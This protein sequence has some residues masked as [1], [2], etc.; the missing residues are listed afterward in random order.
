M[1]RNYFKT[2]VRNLWK[3]KTFSF[4]NVI[5][6]T[7]GLTSFILIALFIFDELTFDRLHKHVDNIYRVVERKTDAAGNTTN[8]AGAGLQVSARAK[9]DIPGIKD[10]ARIST[11][12]RANVKPS[13]NRTNIFYEDLIAGNAGILSV[14]SFPLLYGD[15]STALT[16]PH[17]VIITEESAKKFF[18]TSNAV[19]KLL[20]MWDSVPFRV[21]GVLKNFPA[22]SSISFNLMISEATF[23]KDAGAEGF[24]SN[25]WSSG[26]FATY[27][28]VSNNTD[29]P[30]LNNK[31]DHLIAA[32]HKADAG[33][34][35]HMQL[36][37]LKDVHFY[38]N[39]IEG[40][41]GKKGNISYIY[42]FLIVACFII[43]IACIN[44]M[45]L[46]TARFTNRGKEIAVRKV[47][48]ASRAMLIKQF[49][50]EA[51]L[52][53]VLSALLS[54]MLVN[55]LLPAFNSFTEKHLTINLHTDYRIWTGVL[56]IVMIVTLLAG[57]YPALFQS[58][59]N[60]LSLLKSKVKLGRGNI[61]LRRS[62][63]VFQFMI[64]IVLIAATI[65]IYE[66]MQYVNNKDMG[67][68]KEKS[69]VVAINS[70]DIRHAAATIK[71]EFT[72]LALVKS[73]A[74]T[75]RV[76]GDWKTITSVKVNTN[77]SNPADGKDMFF[78]G[79]D[80]QFLST[81]NI[82]LLKGRNFYSS[83]NGDSAAVLINETA[84]KQLGITNALDQTITIPSARSGSDYRS[85]LEKPFTATVVG[86]VK[87]F[88]FQ[89]LH[90]SIAPMVLGAP[91]NPVH[92]FDYFT[93]K[94][95]GGD[96]SATLTKMSAIL[97]SV[98][99]DNVFEYRFLD[100]QWDLLYRED[101]IRQTVFLIVALLAIFIAALGLLG[102]TIYAAEQRVKE[103]GIRKVLGAS[104]SG[105]VWM[106]STD[107][108]KL[109]LIA[110]VIAVPV[111][112]FFM[113]KW[114]EDFAYRISI[115]WWVFVWSALVAVIIAMATI[116]LQ[117]VKAAIAN[118]V[119]SLKTE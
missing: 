26:A 107:F 72:K 54:L 76:P 56:L 61:S 69:V 21:T 58:G 14:F 84:A 63:V 108:L 6:L 7:I 94:L 102:L 89:S 88:N 79:V 41:S 114:L 44:Y 37:A 82:K 47:S 38:S 111:A 10:V 40:D 15:R 34:Q 59:L 71:D 36:Q 113:H 85:G 65:I 4:I 95:A 110:A 16:A 48:G 31:L 92:N 93:V 57:L 103:I 32:N 87:D 64:S 27:F 55:L 35:S 97:R 2:A 11:Y 9:T 98:D 117:V 43:F 83:G 104:V 17:T 24:F 45:N 46:S 53:T 28:L 100:K 50:A 101:K 60:P 118:P 74:A 99:P 29:I 23:Q 112:W 73:A 18:G 20:L 5:G 116:C 12:N 3:H 90:E 67:F 22:N 106:L 1:F 80:D 105:I 33:V 42:V 96:V 25:D 8:R 62:L 115:S 66:Q 39:D 75:S 78:L 77:G 109:V 81:Y 13:D 30:A 49:L 52:V 68:D 70:G 86:I 19:G 119:K 51:L 91:K